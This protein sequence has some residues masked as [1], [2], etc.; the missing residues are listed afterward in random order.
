M[1]IFFFLFCRISEVAVIL[2]SLRR[3]KKK[4]D[5]HLSLFTL[6]DTKTRLHTIPVHI[7]MHK[8]P[9]VFH[10]KKK[11]NKLLPLP[12]LR[13]GCFYRMIWVVNLHIIFSLLFSFFLLSYVRVAFCCANVLQGWW[14]DLVY[15][16]TKDYVDSVELF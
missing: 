14:I 9:W 12:A 6:T 10:L 15:Q 2:R 13:K 4:H 3:F 1:S 8:I 11:V 5:W 16:D 7:W